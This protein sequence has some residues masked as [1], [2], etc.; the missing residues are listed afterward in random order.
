VA[1]PR[2]EPAGPLPEDFAAQ[3]AALVA[4]G[5][6]EDAAEVIAEAA[7]L[8]DERLAA[9]LEAFASRVAGS[10]ALLTAAELDRLL[11]GAR[12]GAPRPRLVAPS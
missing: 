5:Q 1:P 6:A 2:R 3:L 11:A 12:E 10:S 4:P 8:D 7:L 9:F